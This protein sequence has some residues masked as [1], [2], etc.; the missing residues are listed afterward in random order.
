MSLFLYKNRFREIEHY[1]LLTNGSSAVI[2]S[3][4]NESPNSWLKHHNNPHDRRPSINVLWREKQHVRKKQIHSSPVFLSLKNPQVCK[5]CL[6]CAYF[7]PDSDETFFTRERNENDVNWWTEMLWII[8]MFLS[9][10][11]TLILTAPIHL[12]W[13]IGEQVMLNFSNLFQWRNKL[14][15]YYYFKW[16]NMFFF[17]PDGVVTGF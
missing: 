13:S 1:I 17:S 12:R 8:V 5:W 9:V 16:R 3:C 4:Q 2:D 14:I 11:W 10:V 6:I 7:S 15:I